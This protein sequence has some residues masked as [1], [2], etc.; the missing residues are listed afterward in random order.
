MGE[1]KSE[2]SREEEPS[3]ER[4]PARAMVPVPAQLH[5]LPAL[6]PWAAHCL[7]FWA[8]LKWEDVTGSPGR[9]QRE[10]PQTRGS[11]THG[12]VCAPPGSRCAHSGPARA[13][14]LS[15]AGGPRSTLCCGG[16]CRLSFGSTCFWLSF[17]RYRGSWG[18]QAAPGSVQLT[19]CWEGLGTALRFDLR[20]SSGP[21][22][23]CGSHELVALLALDPGGG[24]R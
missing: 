21:Q 11:Q 8:S 3:L 1:G 16:W 14:S 22:G 23:T 17:W 12:G 7:G 6:P 5:L 19:C 15:S 24:V 18:L 20:V 9:T 10:L 2:G 13:A 4:S